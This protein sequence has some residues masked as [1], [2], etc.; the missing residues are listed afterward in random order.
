LREITAEI[1]KADAPNIRI[2]AYT[3]GLG[4]AR[5]NQRLSQA[6]ANTVRQ[7]FITWGK[8]PSERITAKGRGVA[9][10]CARETQP[11]GSDNPAER[12][13]HRRVEISY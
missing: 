7:W 3:D 5:Y 9:P 11:D 4:S 2:E 1:R 13:R 6:R 10:D 12:A 8:I